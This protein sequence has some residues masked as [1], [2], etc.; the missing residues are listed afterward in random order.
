MANSPLHQK[1][2]AIKKRV[3]KNALKEL[4]EIQLKRRS[5]TRSG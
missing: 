2:T 3:A 1:L 5:D 4:V